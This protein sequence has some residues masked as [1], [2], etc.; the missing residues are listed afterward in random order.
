VKYRF[1]NVL[2]VSEYRKGSLKIT[3]H[4]IEDGSKVKRDSCFLEIRNIATMLLRAAERGINR[5][6]QKRKMGEEVFV[7]VHWSCLK[8]RD[9]YRTMGKIQD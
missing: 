1:V 6:V 3:H 5:Y 7:R 2:R 9:L 8:C 4:E